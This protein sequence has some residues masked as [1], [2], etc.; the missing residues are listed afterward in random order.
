MTPKRKAFETFILKVMDKQDP[1]GFNT[2]H[3]KSFFAG[4][5]DKQF[6]NWVIALHTKKAKI[7][8]YQPPYIVVLKREDSIATAKF[9]GIT[10]EERIR[11]WDSDGQRFV[12]TPHRYTILRLPVRR[13]KQH[14]EDGLSVPESDR[15][16]NP[17]TDQVVQPDKGSAISAPQSQV[18][19]SQNLLKT[20]SEYINVRGGDLGAYNQYKQS[21]ESTGHV[22]LDEI[23]DTTGVK[24]AEV[25]S[26]LLFGM[27]IDNNV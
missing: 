4:L 18:M 22:R 6:D 7:P 10:I 23:T 3:M 19:V 26:T 27:G 16:L 15:R 25:L 2:N 21:L 17:L 5:S 20:T 11:I 1:S 12:L 24:S 9:L 14:R 8:L 13:L